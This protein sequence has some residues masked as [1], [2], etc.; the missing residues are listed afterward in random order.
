LALKTE[1]PP[2]H[3]DDGVAAAV[4]L[5]RL[6]TVTLSVVVLVQ[7]LA[8]VAV[9]VYVVVTVGE[10]VGEPVKLPGTQE[11]DVPPVALNTLEPPKQ[12][13]VGDADATTLGTL[14]TVTPIVEVLVHP[15]ALV[16]VTV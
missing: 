11:Y 10:T 16:A 14:F 13:V 6:F 8:L 7:P 15:L 2:K 3:I 9:T 1:V 4:T 12:I 5:G